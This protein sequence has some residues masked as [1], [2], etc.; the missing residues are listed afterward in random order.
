MPES[1]NVVD[2]LT[3]RQIAYGTVKVGEGQSP[4]ELRKVTSGH[5]FGH[6]LRWRDAALEPDG[7]YAIVDRKNLL[8]FLLEK[9]GQPVADYDLGNIAY[10]TYE[11]PA[12]PD[13][14]VANDEIPADISF[15]GKLKLTGLAYGHTATSRE[16][17]AAAL[18][19]KRVPSGHNAWAVLRWQAQ[20]PV[21]NNLKTSL[22]LVDESGHLAGQVDNLLLSDL[23][24]FKPNWEA[25]EQGSTYHIL[26]TLQGVPPGRY[27][28]FLAVYDPK[29]M[30]RLPVLD[31]NGN[32]DGIGRHARL[33]GYYAASRCRTGA[34]R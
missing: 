8:R 17:P 16:E 31:A 32:A 7:A 26:P 1:N 15:G 18:D 22:F 10:T 2:F 13:Y 28:L 3:R 11:L 27:Q 14:R 29:T 34:A 9:H 5:H 19:E 4:D 21:E 24:L 6:L 23:Y 20:Q 12:S 25:G 33:H 30:Q